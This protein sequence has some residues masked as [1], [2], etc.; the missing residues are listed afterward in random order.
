MSSKPRSNGAALNK[1]IVADFNVAVKNKEIVLLEGVKNES[2]RVTFAELIKK[3]VQFFPVM[4]V[5]L[6]TVSE[7]SEVIIVHPIGCNCFIS[8]NNLKYLYKGTGGFDG[9]MFYVKKIGIEDTP[10]DEMVE[11]VAK[12]VVY[13]TQWTTVL[14]S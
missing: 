11:W 7:Y 9:N 14:S 5:R 1:K 13:K 3:H 8:V 10:V 6:N 12:Q 2:L 4:S